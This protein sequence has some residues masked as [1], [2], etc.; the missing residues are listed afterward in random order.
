[1]LK[2][3]EGCASSFATVFFLIVRINSVLD[4]DNT[5]VSERH[6]SHD[7]AIMY[8]ELGCRVKN[9]I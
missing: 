3:W 1:M 7:Y 6:V 9:G 2:N 8:S 4:R 5:H